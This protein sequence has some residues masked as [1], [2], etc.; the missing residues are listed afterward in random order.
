M[1]LSLAHAPSFPKVSWILIRSFDQPTGK[2]MNEVKRLTISNH[3]DKAFHGFFCWHSNTWQDPEVMKNK[4]SNAI[5]T[6]EQNLRAQKRIKLYTM[7]RKCVVWNTSTIMCKFL[8]KENL[9]GKIPTRPCKNK[10]MLLDCRG[11]KF[12]LYFWQVYWSRA[13]AANTKPVINIRS[14]L[15]LSSCQEI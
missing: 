12:K 15:V 6:I 10:T 9:L 3:E 4:T 8:M 7:L 1:G 13:D 2:N 11:L 5:Q 14:W